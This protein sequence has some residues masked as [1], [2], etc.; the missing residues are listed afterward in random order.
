MTR[1]E[2]LL[3]EMM[4][5]E[6]AGDVMGAQE[7]LNEIVE[8]GVNGGDRTG[9][10]ENRLNYDYGTAEK[11]VE[12]MEVLAD[13]IEIAIRELEGDILLEEDPVKRKI[14]RNDLDML[15]AKRDY[16]KF[17]KNA[18]EIESKLESMKRT[19]TEDS[20]DWSVLLTPVVSLGAIFGVMALLLA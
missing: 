19:Q 20:Y 16:A 8:M 4:R 11:T 18:A 15:K 5:R 12:K 9:E 14:M 2:E 17:N 6:N 10:F 1:R 3:W 13:D 7:I